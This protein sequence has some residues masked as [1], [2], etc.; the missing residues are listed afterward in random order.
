MSKAINILK[1]AL[2][3]EKQGR[4]FFKDK[5]EVFKEP[6]TRDLFLR[7][8]AVE[9]DHYDLIKKELSSYED[10][11]EGYQVGDDVLKHDETSIFEQ[12]KEAESLDTTLEESHV[13]DLNILRMAYLIE[14]DFKEFYQEA[15][16]MVEEDNVKDLLKRL[17]SWEQGH[18]TLFKKEYDRLKQEYLMMPWGG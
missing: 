3:M 2:N 14:R 5:A 18:E 17:A 7:L 8:A 1:Y 9:Q 16:D 6:T 11:P 13:P 15:V 4:D 10:D 12:R